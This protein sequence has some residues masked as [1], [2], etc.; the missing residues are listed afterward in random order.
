MRQRHTTYT[1]GAFIAT[2][3]FLIA[4]LLCGI[5]A[6]SAS[7]DSNVTFAVYE[8]ANCAGAASS[9]YSVVP[10]GVTCLNLATNLSVVVT[11]IDESFSIYAIQVY[12]GSSCTSNY[13]YY[14]PTTTLG[15]SPCFPVVSTMSVSITVPNNAPFTYSLYQSASCTE[16]TEW[17]SFGLTPNVCQPNGYGEYILLTLNSETVVSFGRYSDSNCLVESGDPDESWTKGVGE[18][19]S[20]QNQ[21][22]P[23]SEMVSTNTNRN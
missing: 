20:F 3:A 22:D 14:T 2:I 21:G 11:T 8:N 10:D 7:S 17:Y 18:C 16:L 5:T 19:F 9:P 6:T 4:S 12:N 13:Q 23:W 15:N 1:A